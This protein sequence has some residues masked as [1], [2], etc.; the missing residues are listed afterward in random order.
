[1]FFFLKITASDVKC[2]LKKK[3]GTLGTSCL[4][5]EVAHTRGKCII[6]VL[7]LFPRL[8]ISRHPSLGGAPCSAMLLRFFGEGT[9]TKAHFVRNKRAE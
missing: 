3:A 6:G 1:M 5:T 8:L 7:H 9:N 2:F 4:Q